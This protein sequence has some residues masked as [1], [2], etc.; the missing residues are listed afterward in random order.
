VKNW[1]LCLVLCVVSFGLLTAVTCADEPV[2][3]DQWATSLGESGTSVVVQPAGYAP[4]TCNGLVCGQ[5]IRNVGRVVIA[6]KPVRRVG[7]AIVRAQPLR[8][9]ANVV[10]TVRPIRRVGKA[11]GIVIRARPLARLVGLR[12]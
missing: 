8:R 7:A 3:Y 10:A 4:A 2:A 6:A 5:P 12:Q 9:A 11:V 1:I